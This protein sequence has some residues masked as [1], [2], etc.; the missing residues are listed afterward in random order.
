M[1]Q[2][3]IFSA[4]SAAKVEEM[5]NSFLSAEKGAVTDIRFAREYIGTM[6][7]PESM[8]TVMVVYIKHNGSE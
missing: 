2:V 7:Q 3:K 1:K 4:N 8:T 6:N 5:V